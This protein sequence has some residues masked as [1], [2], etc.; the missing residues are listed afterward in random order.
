MAN[1]A[2]NLTGASLQFGTMTGDGQFAA[3]SNAQVIGTTGGSVRI[4]ASSTVV[5]GNIVVNGATTLSGHLTA[6]GGITG[7][8]TTATRLQTARTIGTS[9][10]V[11]GSIGFDGSANVTMGTTI[12]ALR[13]VPIN[14]TTT[15]PTGSARLN[16]NG[17]LYATRV[18][19]AVW[20]DIVD[21]IEIAEHTHI[22]YGRVYIRQEDGTI[23][24]AQKR[25]DSRA[26]G[27]ASDTY[28]LAMGQDETKPQMP[29]AIGG[30]V[31]AYVDQEYPTGTPLITNYGGE[32]TKA[33]LFT[34]VLHPER[35]L[36]TYYRSE[37]E[38]TWNT[39]VLVNSRAWVKVK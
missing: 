34:R 29:I 37:K 17:Y 38:D 27:I 10:D 35:I 6:P 11:V 21:F 5:S 3:D 7:N 22:E 2:A 26:I 13:G 18:Y 16:I 9:G 25:G 39:Q 28:G 15:N 8:T 14:T 4:Q 30:F 20:N 36:A 31:L 33:D 24:L 12:H 19:N 32:L 1:N 23:S